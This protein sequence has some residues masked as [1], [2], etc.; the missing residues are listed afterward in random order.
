M[1]HA[2][3]QFNTFTAT[4]VRR[5]RV[6]AERADVAEK[7]QLQGLPEIQSVSV[8]CFMAAERLSSLISFSIKVKD[9]FVYE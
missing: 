6:W 2:N 5:R 4:F 7:I 8:Q 1:T 3:I 9:F